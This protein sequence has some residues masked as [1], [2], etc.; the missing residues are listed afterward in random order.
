LDAFLDTTI[1]C[2]S[3]L[4]EDARQK[5]VRQALSTYQKTELPIYALREFRSGALANWVLGHNVLTSSATF[6]EAGTLMSRRGAFAPRKLSVGMTALS[7]GLSAVLN[8]PATALPAPFHSGQGTAEEALKREVEAWIARKVF[9][10]WQKRKKVASHHTHPLGCF[11]DSD[12]AMVGNQIRP[13]DERWECATGATCGAA[14]ELKQQTADV[15]ALVEALKEPGEGKKEKSETSG[16]RRALKDVLAK[17][18]KEFSHKRCRAIGD[19]YFCIVAPK[20]ADI[21]TSNKVDFEPLAAPLNKKLK[22]I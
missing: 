12:L 17:T 6:A 4:A 10:A 3:L 7:Q 15:E 14:L 9:Q 5:A 21:L 13:K 2:D 1:L 8:V 18:P 20:A 11:I 22:V 16:R 19:A